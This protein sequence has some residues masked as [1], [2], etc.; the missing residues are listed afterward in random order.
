MEEE[1]NRTVDDETDGNQ[2]ESIAFRLIEVQI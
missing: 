2:D 1:E